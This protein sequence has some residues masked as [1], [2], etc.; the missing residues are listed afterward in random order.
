M[1]SEPGTPGNA[2]FG[3][4]M[5][6]GGITVTGTGLATISANGISFGF[7]ETITVAD[8]VAGPG[9]DLL[10]S[11]KI[12]P[13]WEGPLTKA[14]PG[15]L[16]LT[17]ANT[18]PSPWTVSSGTLLVNGSIV[19]AVTVS[20]NATVGGVG[21]ISGVVTN[22]SNGHIA[23]GTNSTGGT[24]TL[25]GGLALNDGSILDIDVDTVGG[26]GDAIV[27]SGGT[28]TGAASSGGVTVNVTA[29]GE[30]AGRYTLIDW[31]GAAV[32][33]VDLSDFGVVYNGEDGGNRLS[34]ADDKLMLRTGPLGMVMIT[35]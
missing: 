32:D 17:G 11:S 34:I 5:L 33:S 19:G 10:I 1:T 27:V 31:S 8:T 23:P 29:I 4:F 13:N 15:T 28:F 20:S 24:L 2:G 18:D 25:A 30:G 35:N 12:W 6:N 14:G 16:E 9:T 21:T 26:T 7:D 3:N 22:L